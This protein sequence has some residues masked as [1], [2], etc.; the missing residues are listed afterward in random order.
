MF[1][2]LGFVSLCNL[3][4]RTFLRL[5]SVEK[6]DLLSFGLLQLSSEIRSYAY[7]RV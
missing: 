1:G 3:L 4:H 2:L 5:G 7:M 6:G